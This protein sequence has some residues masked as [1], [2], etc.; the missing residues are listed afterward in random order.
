MNVHSI[1]DLTAAGSSGCQK[2]ANACFPRNKNQMMQTNH[3]TA[4]HEANHFKNAIHTMP[5]NCRTAYP[6][7]EELAKN[8]R[9]KNGT[10]PIASEKH[11]GTELRTKDENRPVHN[12]HRAE[13][14]SP[15]HLAN[16]ADGT[17]DCVCTTK[18]LN[19]SKFGKKKS[20]SPDALS[21]R[22]LKI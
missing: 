13:M 22:E 10:K 1:H 4:A 5:Q 21:L 20:N 8:F 17:D 14:P 6:F 15:R 19:S 2:H 7:C 12:G 11:S 16:V 9:Q 18:M 3:E